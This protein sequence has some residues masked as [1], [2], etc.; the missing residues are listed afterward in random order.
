MTF[1]RVLSPCRKFV[2]CLCLLELGAGAFLLGSVIVLVF[3]QVVARYGFNEPRAWIEEICTYAFIWLVFLGAGAAMK[4]NRHIRVA[5]FEENAGRGMKIFMRV[6][7]AFVTVCAL[8][9][10]AFHAGKFVAVEMRST[11]VS[12]PVNIPRAFFFSVPLI[13]ACV[14]ISVSMLY[15]LACDL[16]EIKTGERMPPVWEAASAGRK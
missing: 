2:R 7:G 3:F 6:L 8:V 11:S 16:A 1:S 14:S 13:W 12:L 10:V 15:V 5:S 9:V 4:L